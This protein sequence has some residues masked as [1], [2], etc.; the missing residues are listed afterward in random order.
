MKKSLFALILLFVAAGTFYY[1]QQ[2][3]YRPKPVKVR[4]L[5]RQI[6]QENEKLIA[7]QIIANELK[8]VT[9]LIEGNLAQSARDS[10]AEDASL[11]FMNQLTDI[12]RDHDIDLVS[13]DPGARRSYA[14]YLA[15]PYTLDVQTS[16]KSLV[17][18]LND[19]EKSNRLATVD[20]L[21][22]NST[23]KRVQALAK[24]G[25]M[26]KRPMTIT[27]STLTLIKHK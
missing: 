23:V 16:Y 12:L 6:Q 5:D 21:D 26:E 9:K 4:E 18:F 20:R 7:A 14:D 17:D 2:Y 1:Y 15:T 27:L 19:M 24:E 22:L 3:V 8:Q 25:K 13:I 10:L 11:P